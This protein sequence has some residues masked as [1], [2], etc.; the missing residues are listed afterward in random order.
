MNILRIALLAVFVALSGCATT[1][2]LYA[3]YDDLCPV[4]IA[5]TPVGLVTV[6]G[7][8]TLDGSVRTDTW[9]PA[10]YFGFDN[11]VLD[12]ENRARLNSNL[13]VL[14][15]YPALQI[16][17]QAFT[18]QAGDAVYNRWLAEQ[19]Q[20]T[21]VNFLV[22]NGIARQRMNVAAPAMEAPINPGT[23]VQERIVNRRVE[24]MPLDAQGRP[25]LLRVDFDGSGD[26]R[27][28]AP[29]PVK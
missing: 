19:R 29:A 2:A 5:V 22:Q 21:V 27:F 10:V 26:E 9:E 3:Q 24:L 18:D 11:A 12:D 17:I 23:G 20:R 13:A 7:I 28:V 6:T 8:A 16:S 15:H 14:N 4:E 25:L 1:D